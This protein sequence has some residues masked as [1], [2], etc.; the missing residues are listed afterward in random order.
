LKRAGALTF[1][2]RHRTKDGRVFPVEVNANYILAGGKEINFAFARDIS[3]RKRAEEAL[4]ASE[5]TLAAAQARAH[6][7]SW[8]LDVRTRK[9]S[10]SA[11]MSRLFHRD[12]ALEAPSFEEFRA[13]LHPG[14]RDALTEN[15]A[16]VATFTTPR[17]LEYRTDPALGPM[18]YL[19]ATL[20]VLRDEAGQPAHLVG[21]TLD[22][23]ERMLAEE[24]TRQSEERYRALFECAPDGIVIGTPACDYVDANEAFRRLLGYSREELVGMNVVDIVVKQEEPRL[25][26]TVDT[27]QTGH[28]HQEEWILRR[29][30]G[31]TFSAEV[32]AT[33]LPD[34]NLMAIIRDLTERKRLEQH[35]LR[36]QRMESIGTLAGGIA[37]DLNNVL[38]PIMM[39]LGLLRMRFSDP[40]SRELL[41]TISASAEHGASMIRQVLSFARGVEGQRI[42]LQLGHLIREVEK[43]ANDTFLKN[44]EVRSSVPTD[45]WTVIGDPTQ[46][47]QVLMNLCV[48]ARDAMPAGGTLRLEAENLLVDKQFTS[49]ETDARPGPYV[50]LKVEDTGTGM[51]PEVIARIFDPFFTTKEVGKGTGLGL[52][53]ALGIVKSHGGFLRVK[54]EPGKGTRFNIY[55]PAQLFG[56]GG[57]E[58]NAVADLPC[59]NGELVLVVD[60]EAAV[61]LITHQTLEAFGYRVIAAGDG[62]EAVALFAARRAEI[63]VV[64]TDMVMPVMD[65]PATVQMLR[66]L[67]PGL[68]V[69]GTSG[70][71]SEAQVAVAAS[72]GVKHFLAKPYTA[73]K[74]L[75]TL[76][77]ILADET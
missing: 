74:L 55:F 35:F 32:I 11:E 31:S 75:Q 64:L 63:A 48:N 27:I 62:A 14:D 46:L 76:R 44:I 58:A 60:D 9:G 53:T 71:S 40:A 39:S 43:I 50:L 5:A 70:Y 18:R 17:V 28:T 66:T 59:G 56:E 12:P 29:K 22:V 4:R 65:G 36:A 69:I 16:S 10:W 77:E 57:A 34:G 24:A 21:T 54:S 3:E 45:L 7:G 23:T 26:P 61:R 2:S 15:L 1:E 20:E 42:E 49:H 13:L 30:D 25:G 68:R 67:K 37:H 73:D 6:L 47:H 52:S 19:R 33:L 8:E 51:P 72:L 41:S 38:S